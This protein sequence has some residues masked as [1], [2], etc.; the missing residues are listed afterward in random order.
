MK[1]KRAQNDKLGRLA[2]FAVQQR[3]DP[4]RLAAVKRIISGKTRCP[5]C[6]EPNAADQEFCNH[7][8]ARLY[9]K[10]VDKRK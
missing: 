7:C 1:E 9:P 3:Y 6:D 4:E 5:E 8:S 10:H 2:G